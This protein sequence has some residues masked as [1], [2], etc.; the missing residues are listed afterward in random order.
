MIP[1]WIPSLP[2]HLHHFIITIF[3]I[4][5]FILIIIVIILSS[6]LFN[7]ITGI[8]SSDFEKQLR[9]MFISYDTDKS[10]GLDQEEF[11]RCLKSLE[12]ELTETEMVGLMILA[13]PG[14]IGIYTCI[15]LLIHMYHL[16]AC[17]YVYFYVHLYLCMF[18][19]IWILRWWCYF[20]SCRVDDSS[21]PLYCRGMEGRMLKMHMSIHICMSTYKFVH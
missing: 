6:F 16:F 11:I 14:N 19:Y 18:M 8:S 7:S 12:L 5:S 1:P 21:G 10:G 17:I 4:I 3:I 20:I 2:L 9:T 13:D 15:C